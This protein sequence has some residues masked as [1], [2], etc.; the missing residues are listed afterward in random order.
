MQI[1]VIPIGTES[2]SVGSYIADI[3]QFLR[4]RGVEHYLHDMGTVISG[5]TQELLQLALEVHSLPFTKGAERVITNITLDERLDM[6]RKIGDKQ[7]S[8]TRRLQ[9]K[10][11]VS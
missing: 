6:D 2:T 5:T 8:V 4:D 1:T 3:E 11:E 10:S 9:K 7:Q